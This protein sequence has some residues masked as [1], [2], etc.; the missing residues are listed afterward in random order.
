MKKLILFLSFLGIAEFLFSQNDFFT[1][2]WSTEDIPKSLI[3]YV[4]SEWVFDGDSIFIKEIESDRAGNGYWSKGTFSVIGDTL[5]FHITEKA[6]LSFNTGFAN[7]WKCSP[8]IKKFV[9]KK[10]C[11]SILFFYDLDEFNRMKKSGYFY[12]EFP[13]YSII[14]KTDDYPTKSWNFNEFC[15]FHWTDY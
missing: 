6:K 11:D 12:S 5:N 13:T 9:F 1:G 2:K 7:H 3:F 8:Y 4:N 15:K 14:E 10:K